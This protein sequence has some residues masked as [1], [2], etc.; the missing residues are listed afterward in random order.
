M[1]K[2]PTIQEFMTDPKYSEDS[3]FLREVFAF[4]EGEKKAKQDEE[5]KKKPKGFL[6]SLFGGDDD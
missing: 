1:A 4:I 2:K 5:N 6:D 3:N